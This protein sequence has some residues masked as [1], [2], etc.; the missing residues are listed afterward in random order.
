MTRNLAPL[1]LADLRKS[2]LTD[3]TIEQHRFE[4]VRP[5]DIPRLIGFDITGL[6]SM[7]RLPFPPFEDDYERFRLFYHEGADTWPN[8]KRKPKYIQRIGAANRL[9]IP[10]PVF[11]L[12]ADPGAMLFITEGEKK[13]LAATQA[14][15]PC[16]GIT[17][18]WNWKRPGPGLDELLPDFD[19]IAWRG[20]QVRLVPDNDWRD[21]DRHGRKKNLEAAVTRLARCLM[22]RGASVEI[23][24]IPK[25]GPNH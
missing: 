16:L 23:V 11:P 13:A 21:H 4:S 3:T 10:V 14:G 15:F 9:Y 6:A 8:G 17:G 5:C 18:L 1:H 7:Y 12:L 22:L 2:G 24:I 19:R 20:R 25:G